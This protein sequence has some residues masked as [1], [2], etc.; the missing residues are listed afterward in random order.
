MLLTAFGMLC[1]NAP[2]KEVMLVCTGAPG[3]RQQWLINAA[4]RMGLGPRVIFPGYLSH[5]ELGCV[6]AAS[7]GLIFPSLYEGFGLPVIEAMAAGVPVACSNTTSL[8]EV[9]GDAAVLFNP[10]IP[11]EIAEAMRTLLQEGARA[12]RIE[13]G[14]ARALDFSD[15][16]RMANDYWALFQEACG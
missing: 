6:M 13:K 11:F 4:T 5:D 8:P 15:T 10:A 1:Q 9:A 2:H 14:R 12:Q 3:E 7:H 16:R